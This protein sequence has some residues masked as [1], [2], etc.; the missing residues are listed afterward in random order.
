MNIRYQKFPGP[1]VH[2]KRVL[3]TDFLL[4]PT[5]ITDVFARRWAGSVL[6]T[7]VS[8]LSNNPAMAAERMDIQPLTHEVAETGRVQIATTSNNTVLRKATDFPGHIGQ[9]IHC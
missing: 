7:G 5:A 8:M 2:K 3:W 1:W 9:N 4:Y 6:T